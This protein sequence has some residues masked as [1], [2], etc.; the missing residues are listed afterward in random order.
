MRDV[1]AAEVLTQS[2]EAVT[3][4]PYASDDDVTFA[5]SVP[6]IYF[7]SRDGTF[8][9]RMLLDGDAPFHVTSHRE[10]F[11]IF[12]SGRYG[13]VHLDADGSAYAIAGAGDI[14]LLLP[15]G[16]SFT[17]C[18]VRYVPGLRQSLISVRQLQDSGCRIVLGEHSFQMHCGSLV[19]A[20]GSPEWL[21][22]SYAC[23]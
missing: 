17:L 9:S 19:I 11:D 15:S 4:A 1:D 12:S 14:C 22:L 23:I 16:A 7:T 10:W 2:R 8:S 5:S 18:H 20:E 6:P 3:V 13:C 21:D